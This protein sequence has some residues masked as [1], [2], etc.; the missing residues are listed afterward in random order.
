M[1]VKPAPGYIF[2]GWTDNFQ[3]DPTYYSGFTVEPGLELVANFIPNPFP[4]IQGEYDGLISD[5]NG[6]P[7]G[8]FSL[9]LNGKGQYSG[10]I[11]VN[12]RGYEL[13]FNV[14]TADNMVAAD[15]HVQDW[16]N[17][18][19]Y[20]GGTFGTVWTADFQFDLTNGTGQVTGTVSNAHLVFRNN[21]LYWV[22][23]T[24]VAELTGSRADQTEK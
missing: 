14:I 6:N 9:H 18:G 24:W 12:G 2:A 10:H 13:G 5:T 23:A 15:G 1:K 20:F 17:S 22:P 11:I 16:V 21:E 3:T 8:R 4:A 7:T 19:G